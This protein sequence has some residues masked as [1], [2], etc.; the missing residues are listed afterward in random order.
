MIYAAEEQIYHGRCQEILWLIYWVQYSTRA[1]DGQTAMDWLPY[2]HGTTE[3]VLEG[4]RA[5]P[6]VHQYMQERTVP[7]PQRAKAKSKQLIVG[8]QY[9]RSLPALD[10]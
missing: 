9:N 5:D 10:A 4:A 8:F 6:S 1:K 3:P 7:V 2:M